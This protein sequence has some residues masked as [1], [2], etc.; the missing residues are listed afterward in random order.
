MNTQPAA[1]R[2]TLRGLGEGPWSAG[3]PWLYRPGEQRREPAP[4]APSRPAAQ[5]RFFPRRV[6]SPAAAFDRLTALPEEEQPPPSSEP[7]WRDRSDRS[8]GEQ[9]PYG[10]YMDCRA[11]LAQAPPPSRQVDSGVVPPIR[12]VVD[13][14]TG[15][16]VWIHYSEEEREMN[17][18]GR[19]LPPEFFELQS[20]MRVVADD[21]PLGARSPALRQT[22]RSNPESQ[23]A[24]NDASFGEPFPQF[25]QAIAE[26]VAANSDDADDDDLESLSPG[27]RRRYMESLLPAG[28]FDEGDSAETMHQHQ[29]F[30][31]EAEETRRLREELENCYGT[32]SPTPAS[33]GQA[34][35]AVEEE[36]DDRYGSSPPRPA[37]YAPAVLTPPR[38]SAVEEEGEEDH[39]GSSLP[40][41]AVEA[42]AV[43]TPS[44]PSSPAIFS[45][46]TINTNDIRDTV[47]P[48]PA[49]VEHFDEEGQSDWENMLT[50]PSS[51]SPTPSAAERE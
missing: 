33:D 25:D 23:M 44:T 40:R 47:H 49:P 26:H 17:E 30:W 9:N 51:P 34:Q 31:S 37:W 7:G 2:D 20:W 1:S 11:P 16:H 15:R 21:D 35:S 12:L 50:P 46:Q 4:P 19:I 39:Y 24:G 42:P 43:L 22:P 13:R 5:S 14:L 6:P 45:P 28:L 3:A 10:L 18:D 41:R 8:D 38:A 29:P 32:P 36:E 48:E 27:R